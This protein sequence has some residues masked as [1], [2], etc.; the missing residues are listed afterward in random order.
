M[1]AVHLRN[2][3]Y[4]TNLHHISGDDFPDVA[5]L[6]ETVHELQA[7]RERAGV[8]RQDSRTALPSSTSGGSCHTTYTCVQIWLHSLS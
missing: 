4:C 6:M 1:Y 5:S 3:D 2:D 7:E 8:D